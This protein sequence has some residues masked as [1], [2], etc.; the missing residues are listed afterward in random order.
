MAGS[1]PLTPEKELDLHRRLVDGDGVAPAELAI[2]YLDCLIASLRT[3]NH[4]KIPQEFIEEAAGE[5]LI[6]LI[7]NPKSFDASRNRGRWPLRAFLRL[8]AQRDLQNILK[9]EAPHWQRRVSLESVELSP[10]GGKYLGKVE[11]PSEALQLQE[12]V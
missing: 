2:A 8:A 3:R 7:K 6:S 10:R 1:S 4:R 9:K 12:E 5:A 11:D